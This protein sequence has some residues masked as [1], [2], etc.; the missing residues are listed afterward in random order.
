MC[1][2]LN[3][4][5]ED[6]LSLLEDENH[7]LRQKALS[8]SPKHN[9]P[10]FAKAFSEVKLLPTNMQRNMRADI[11]SVLFYLVNCCMVL[12]WIDNS[13]TYIFILSF[14]FN[15]FIVYCFYVQSVSNY[16]FL[17]G[18]EI[19]W[20][21]CSSPVWPEACICKTSSLS[22]LL[23]NYE[24][25]C[26]ML[27]FIYFLFVCIFSFFFSLFYFIFFMQESPTP[28]KLIASFSQG[29]SE[30]RRSK[31]TVE[32]HRVLSLLFLDPSVRFWSS[33]WYFDW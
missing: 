6:K 25:L 32:R 5:L 19:F 7:V 8:V 17:N 33:L 15:V 31:L 16:Y 22:V 13:P 9:R 12:C 29:L 14:A 26:I 27:I 2:Y 3:Y 23:L 11:L 10:G 21:T 18:A 24:L 20:C 1:C 30:S 4:S 28:T